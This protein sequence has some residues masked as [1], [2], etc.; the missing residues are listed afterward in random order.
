MFSPC[1][2]ITLRHTRQQ[3]PNSE[4]PHSPAST[5]RGAVV[6]ELGW[7]TGAVM[8]RKCSRIYSVKLAP[9]QTCHALVLYACDPGACGNTDT[10]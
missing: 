7:G 5:G 3:K 9:S 2:A 1:S 10:M 6:A 8:L 4:D